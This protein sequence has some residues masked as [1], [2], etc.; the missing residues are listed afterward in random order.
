MTEGS[1]KLK[2]HDTRNVKSVESGVASHEDIVVAPGEDVVASDG[3]DVVANDYLLLAWIVLVRL[4]KSLKAKHSFQARFI[5]S[6]YA[7]NEQAQHKLGLS[8]LS[9]LEFLILV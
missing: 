8:L 7:W 1:I 2:L 6:S 9:Q 3:Y 4:N 5:S